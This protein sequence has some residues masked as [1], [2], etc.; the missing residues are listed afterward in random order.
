MGNNPA[1][2][3][4]TTTF[5]DQAQNTSSIQCSY[6]IPWRPWSFFLNLFSSSVQVHPYVEENVSDLP[7]ADLEN[8]ISSYPYIEVVGKIF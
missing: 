6:I 4:S 3:S 5:A 2:F 8:R 7:S 1:F